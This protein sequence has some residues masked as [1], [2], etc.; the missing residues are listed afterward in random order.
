MDS[1]RHNGGRDAR[2]ERRSEHV[3]VEG[4]QGAD[5]PCGAPVPFIPSRASPCRQLS[6]TVM[7]LVTKKLALVAAER[8]AGGGSTFFRQFEDI[9]RVAVVR[10]ADL[11]EMVRGT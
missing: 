1:I 3:Q 4:A 10:M 11:G 7:R 2:P 8:G 6:W 9:Q 5:S